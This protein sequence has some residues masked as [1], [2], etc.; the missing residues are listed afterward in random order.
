MSASPRWRFTKYTMDVCGYRVFAAP[1]SGGRD[2]L[3]VAR[4]HTRNV[5]REPEQSFGRCCEDVKPLYQSTRVKF[6]LI[7]TPWFACSFN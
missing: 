5:A 4:R 6:T 3:N 1:V 2:S 7:V